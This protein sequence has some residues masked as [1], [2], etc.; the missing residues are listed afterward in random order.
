MSRVLLKISLCFGGTYCL[1][2]QGGRISQA[3]NQHEAGSKEI[4]MAVSCLDYSSTLKLETTCS[5][6]TLVDF[7]ESTHHYIA[8]NKTVHA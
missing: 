2:L 5:S 7:Q 4:F 8:E 3:R 6:K 1:H